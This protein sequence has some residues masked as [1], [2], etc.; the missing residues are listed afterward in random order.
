MW[1]QCIAETVVYRQVILIYTA[2]SRVGIA[3][4]ECG[5]RDIVLGTVH[6]IY[7]AG[8]MDTVDGSW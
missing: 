6:N 4:K 3:C 8:A 2:I 7:N 5:A 1:R